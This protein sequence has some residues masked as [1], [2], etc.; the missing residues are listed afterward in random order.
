MP[1][2]GEII[3]VS[4]FLQPSMPQW[5]GEELA[6]AE[7]LLRTPAD[8]VNVTLLTMTT[9][10][11]THVDAPRHFIDGGKT[12]DQFPLDRWVGPCV[13]IDFTGLNADITAND[14]Q[15]ANVPTD[16][17][18]LVF[19]TRN[20][21]IWRTHAAGFFEGFIALAPSGAR[22]VV[23]HQIRLVAIDYLSIGAVNHEGSE[24]HTTLL[25]NDVLIVE[26]L[27]L[28]NVT[29]GNYELLC[30]PLNVPNV[31]GAPARVALR[32]ARPMHA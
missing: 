11:G 13:V 15:Q 30:F 2:S 24:T 3:D 9:H 27:D 7:P 32:S 4:V 25:G 19:K 23:E 5:A 14:L 29:A 22:W 16:A 26:G 10:T 1:R 8:E 6:A 18:R 28:T 31:D 20:S 17:T 21:G 12:L